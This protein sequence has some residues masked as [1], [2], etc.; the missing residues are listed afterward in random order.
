MRPNTT[1][2]L[3]LA[4]ISN[5]FLSFKRLFYFFNLSSLWLTSI[6]EIS[7]VHDFYIG[8]VHSTLLYPFPLSHSL[9]FFVVRGDQLGLI[10]ETQAH[11]VSLLILDS[12]AYTP[13]ISWLSLPTLITEIGNNYFFF[14]FVF[15]LFN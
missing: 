4:K 7:V 2:Y 8:S 6:I 1:T 10:L 12:H 14:S 15:P 3:L 11:Q 13:T 5:N 9:G